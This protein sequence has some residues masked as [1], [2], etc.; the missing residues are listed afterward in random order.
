MIPCREPPW[1]AI[2]RCPVLSVRWFSARQQDRPLPGGVDGRSRY[3]WCCLTRRAASE[4]TAHAG[5]DVGPRPCW[6]D[7]TRSRRASSMIVRIASVALHPSVR[8]TLGW[9]KFRS[10]QGLW[11]DG[12]RGAVLACSPATRPSTRSQEQQSPDR[13]RRQQQERLR[14]HLYTSSNADRHGGAECSH[15]R[16]GDGDGGGGDHLRCRQYTTNSRHLCRDADQRKLDVH[17]CAATIKIRHSVVM[18]SHSHQ[19]DRSLC[20]REEVDRE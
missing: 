6:K 5:R 12:D 7:A 3:C 17:P 14:H 16:D 15:P 4:M 2:R 13:Q 11:S 18:N 20:V 10:R 19:P 1:A 9:S 8:G